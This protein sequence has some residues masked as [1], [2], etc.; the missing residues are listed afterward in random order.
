MRNIVFTVI[1]A[2][3]LFGC[4]TYQVEVQQGNVIDE[5]MM[6][7]LRIG[8]SKNEVTTLLGT[9]ILIDAFNSNTWTYVYTKQRGK[10]IEKRRLI[11]EFRRDKL[12]LIQ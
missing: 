3:L 2:I 5:K 4:H 8:M 9:P 7:Q 1:V 6:E 10:K 12:V 11:L